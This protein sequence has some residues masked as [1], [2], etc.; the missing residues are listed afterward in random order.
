[1]ESVP[2]IEPDLRGEDE[3]AGN[4]K[5]LLKDQIRAGEAGLVGNREGGARSIGADEHGS[6]RIFQAGLNNSQQGEEE[7]AA[8]KD[9]AG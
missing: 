6:E 1:M 2:R 8:V 3:Q 9:P 5:D 7:A 4:D